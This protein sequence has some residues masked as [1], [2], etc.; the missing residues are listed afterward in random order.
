LTKAKEKPAAPEVAASNPVQNGTERAGVTLLEVLKG[1]GQFVGIVGGGTGSFAALSYG[2]GYLAQKSYDSMLGLPGTTSSTAS[3]IRTGALFFPRAAQYLVDAVT[4]YSLTSIMVGSA[5]GLGLLGIA[6]W[7]GTRLSPMFAGNSALQA[8]SVFV[9]YA[10]LIVVSLVYLPLHVAS[11][12]RANA[13]LLFDEPE[14]DPA[15]STAVT[16]AAASIHKQLRDNGGEIQLHRRFGLEMGAVLLI[17]YVALVLRQLRQR[18]AP[19]EAKTKFWLVGCD[20]VL[21]PLMYAILA[22]LAVH[23][24]SNYGVLGLSLRY[25]CVVPGAHAPPSRSEAQPPV[26]P[27]PAPGFTGILLSD[28]TA[29]DVERVVLLERTTKTGYYIT[30]FLPKDSIS[31]MS[32][33][34]CSADNILAGG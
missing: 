34:S 33:E 32:V 3:Y 16:K 31:T 27:A 10:A 20:W 28:L 5:V 7:I 4:G 12:N 30:H 15:L 26:A 29:P 23:I 22:A 19:A 8:R 24:P 11:I 2:I 13:D 17:V 14:T 25:K 9:L 21:R 1:V 18:I 6:G